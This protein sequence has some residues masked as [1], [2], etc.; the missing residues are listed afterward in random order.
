MDELGAHV[1]AQ[2][3]PE[4]APGRAR[5]IESHVL[6][7]FTKQPNRWAEPKISDKTAAAFKAARVEHG[8]QAVASH[9]SYLINLST[10]D[11]G[12]WKRSVA[13]FTGELQRC[14]ALGVEFVVTH[15]GNATDK[16]F[17][18][19]L[20]KNAEGVTAALEAVPGSTMVLLE[21]TAGSGTSVGATFENLATIV[22]AV[23]EPHRE[24]VGICF[25]TCHAF[26]AG[27]DLIEDWDGVWSHFDD[28]IG[29]DRLR[30]F[31]LNDSQH[32]LGCRKDRH[33]DIGEGHL[34]ERPFQAL[35][36]DDRLKHVPKVLETPKGDD[37]ISGDLENLARLRGYRIN[38]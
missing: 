38:G 7:L 22:Q 11:E 8:I 24:R 5:D 3:G 2:G 9:D 20:A 23:S 26:A 34:G 10:P 21:I 19:G 33:A 14:T 35:M 17:S 32:P 37:G 1:S 31:H 28:I 18:R 29:L 27:Y 16:D 13:C 36:N 25:D 6:Q 15:P 12:Q 4:N 30:F